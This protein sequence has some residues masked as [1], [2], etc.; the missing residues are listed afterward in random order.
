MLGKKPWIEARMYL[1]RGGFTGWGKPM[2]DPQKER[3]AQRLALDMGV[4]TRTRMAAE[5]G[6]DMAA[7]IQE[8]AF[9]EKQL[10]DAGLMP[11]V[12]MPELQPSQNA[13]APKNPEKQSG[14]A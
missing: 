2:I 12:L 11:E 10:K 4:D 6:D 8:R 5:N 7:I 13:D 1:V 3:A 14:S 9:E